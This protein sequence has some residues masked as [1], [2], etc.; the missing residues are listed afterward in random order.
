MDKPEDLLVSG[1]G[2]ITKKWTQKLARLL[3]RLEIN[4]VVG[5]T[6]NK[7]IY[8]QN[9]NVT[10]RHKPQQFGANWLQGGQPKLAINTGYVF[11]SYDDDNSTYLP[12]RNQHPFEPK[13]GNTLL[14]ATTPPTLS[15]TAGSTNYIYL[16]LTWDYF[17]DEIGGEPFG[18]NHAFKAEYGLEVFD[19]EE[20]LYYP[21]QNSSQGSGSYT[22]GI[23]TPI[24]KRTYHLSASEFV[25]ETD[26][27]QAAETETISYILAGY[28]TLNGSGAITTNGTDEGARW[29]LEGPVYTAKPPAYISN[30]SGQHASHRTEP[31]APATPSGQTV[32]GIS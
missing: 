30:V 32:P 6:V 26:Q 15:L 9:I 19:T 28:A 24:K 7:S 5:G 18:G 22:Q 8:G 11:A 17:E 29:Y 1:S 13:I 10:Q 27:A 14:S 2:L 3:K 31:V 20:G 16:K 21:V 23:Y 4:S 25:K 12:M